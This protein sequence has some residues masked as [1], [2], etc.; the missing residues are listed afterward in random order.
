[1]PKP[2]NVE[3]AYLREI[4][5]DNNGKPT[6]TSPS[7][8]T[9]KYFQVQFNPETLK[10]TY[11][12]QKTGGDQVGNSP[13]QVVGQGT[14]KL[15]LQ[16]WFDISLPKKDGSA[17]PNGDVRSLTQEVV[18]FM[19]PQKLQVKGKDQYVPPG[20]SFEWG[21]MIFQGVMDSLDETLDYC[22]TQGHPQRASMH[23]GITQQEIKPQP[24]SQAP[25]TG[26][27]GSGPGT[28]PLQLGVAGLS[29]QQ[30]SAN[31]GISDWRAVADLNGIENPRQV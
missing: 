10:V 12:N 25:G 14:T 28:Q 9:G 29:L 1:M 30:M 19:T 6:T 26:L 4:W 2:E 13:V 11:A 23:V 15:T 16:L 20:V 27:S 18:Y 5:W 21:S 31:L 8:G 24:P 22:S 17:Q 7:G 3:P